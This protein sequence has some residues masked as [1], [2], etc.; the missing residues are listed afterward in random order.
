MIV[1]IVYI[2]P[3][4]K[5]GQMIRTHPPHSSPARLIDGVFFSAGQDSKRGSPG[6]RGGRSHLDCHRVDF[7]SPGGGP[8]H[9]SWPMLSPAGPD[10]V[11]CAIGIGH[12]A[13]GHDH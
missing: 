2:P 12:A 9:H 3:S 5:P 11:A 1:G 6:R 8:R 7:G 13:M 10:F 4:G